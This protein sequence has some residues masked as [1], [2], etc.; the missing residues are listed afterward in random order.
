LE[1]LAMLTRL[2]TISI[3][4]AT[5]AQRMSLRNIPA[6]LIELKF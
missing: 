5:R 1:P 6:G 4:N 2:R 3:K